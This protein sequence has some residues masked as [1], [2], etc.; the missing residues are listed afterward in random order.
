M[1]PTTIFILLTPTLIAVVSMVIRPPV[2][3]LTPSTG[4][5]IVYPVVVP[6]DK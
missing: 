1:P 4:S 3:I 5:S 6:S 2:V